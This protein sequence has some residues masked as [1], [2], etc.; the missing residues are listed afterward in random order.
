MAVTAAATATKEHDEL[1]AKLQ[2]SS[3]DEGVDDWI[4][5]IFYAEPGGGKTHLLGTAADHPDTSPVL[6]FDVEGGL[7][8]L[9]KFPNKKNIERIPVRSMDDIKNKYNELYKAINEGGT[10]PYKTVGIDSGTELTDL[11]MR[12][13]MKDAYSKNPDKVNID[14]PSQREWGIAR[15]HMRTIIRAFRDLPCNVIMTAQ[16]GTL[17]EEGQPIKYFPGFAGK[18]RTE[19]PGFFD[20]VGY[21][22]ADNEGGAIVRRTQFVGTRRV[23]AKD[24]TGALGDVLENVTVPMM[25]NLINNG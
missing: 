7:R 5:A 20:I 11:D 6:I 4:N 19:V 9:R 8:T 16:V 25:W 14:V 23:V 10:I 12:Y 22:S 15:Q 1:R 17:Q 21:L 3:I 13:I 2:V 18:L 24:R